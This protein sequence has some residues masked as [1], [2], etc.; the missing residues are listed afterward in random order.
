[1]EA[2]DKMV[3]LSNFETNIITVLIR[4][5]P[6]QELLEYFRQRMWIFKYASARAFEWNVN[7]PREYR[8][9]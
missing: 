6:S 1:M 5:F 3:Q 4:H 8:E 7:Q 2:I 9:N